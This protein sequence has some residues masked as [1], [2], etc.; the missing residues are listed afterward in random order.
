MVIVVTIKIVR[1]DYV[2]SNAL[3]G[4]FKLVKWGNCLILGCCYSIVE[5]DL[6]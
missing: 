4:F 1:K 2:S 3:R 5:L 6:K